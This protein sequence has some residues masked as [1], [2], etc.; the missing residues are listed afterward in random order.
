V[1]FSYVMNALWEGLDAQVT[2]GAALP[3]GVLMDVHAGVVQR[4]AFGNGLGGVRLPSM[5]APIATYTPGN[6]ADPSLPPLLQSIGNLA[7][8]LS[9]SV[10]PFDDATLDTL[11][12]NHG[13]YV[14]QVVAAANR[15]RSQGFLLSKDRSAIVVAATTSTVGCGIGFELALV[16]PPL[17][18]LHRRRRAAARA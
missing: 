12:P 15:L 1:F 5:E 18:W 8:F 6:S 4:D 11:Y 10:E 3:A 9:S 13:T 7:C 17:M 16:L 2:S 14:S